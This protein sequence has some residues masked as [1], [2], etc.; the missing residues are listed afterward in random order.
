MIDA[1]AIRRDVLRGDGEGHR[2]APA[3]HFH[4]A[5]QV[6]RYAQDVALL[7]GGRDRIALVVQDA[8]ALGRVD[9]Q[10]R[11][12][13]VRD[14][15]LVQ[16]FGIHGGV[17]EIDRLVRARRRVG[18]NV[19]ADD[20]VAGQA[21]ALRRHVRQLERR[22]HSGYRA[23]AIGHQADAAGTRADAAQ[24][25]DDAQRGRAAAGLFAAGAADFDANEIR[26]ALRASR[27]SWPRPWHGRHRVAAAAPRSG[28]WRR[29]YRRLRRL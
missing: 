4:D 6:F 26:L 14:L 2:R 7:D 10:H 29:R 21:V 16:R 1:V 9:G 15:V 13:V 20:G 27:W 24:A 23:V 17:H 12:H 8:I 3:G 28:R 19:R 22:R 5:D 18:T 11:V 25:A